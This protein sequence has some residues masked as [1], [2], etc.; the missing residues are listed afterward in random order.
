MYFPERLAGFEKEIDFKVHVL[1]RYLDSRIIDY[2]ID[3]QTS[4]HYFI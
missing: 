2:I 4:I 3:T 1:V